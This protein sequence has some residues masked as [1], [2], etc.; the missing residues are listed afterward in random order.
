MP[1]ALV[2]LAADAHLVEGCP[3]Y[4][5]LCSARLGVGLLSRPGL[6][7]VGGRHSLPFYFVVAGRA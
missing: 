6:D 5:L 2:D 3:L 4:G 1:A 7:G